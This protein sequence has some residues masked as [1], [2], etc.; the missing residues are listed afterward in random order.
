MKVLIISH[1]HPSSSR[2]GAEIV[3][4][5]LFKQFIE[6]NKIECHV[7]TVNP[8]Q[9]LPL[10]DP[11]TSSHVFNEHH[12]KSRSHPFSCTNTNPDTFSKKIEHL[13]RKIQP[14][15]IHLHHLLHLGIDSVD[16]IRHISPSAKVCL[17][18]HDYRSLCLNDGLMITS[19]QRLTCSTS[20]PDNCKR[21]FP[22]YQ[23]T[24]IQTR[25]DAYQEAV[26]NCDAII[27]PSQFL[28]NQLKNNGF[29]KQYIHLINNGTPYKPLQGNHPIKPNRFGFFG[30][31]CEAK[32][33]L[34][35]LIATLKL[36]KNTNK[37]FNISIFGGGLERQPAAFQHRVAH[38][39]KH[40]GSAIVKW[41]GPYNPND[42][43]ELMRTIDWVVVPSIWWENAP[44]V[45][46][47]AFALSIPV[48]GSNHGGIAEQIDGKGGLMVSANDSKHLAQ[49]MEEAIDNRSLHR[50]LQA[51]IQPPTSIKACA[52]QH[53]ILYKELL[54]TN[55]GK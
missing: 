42:L 36:K 29:C 45:I 39:R 32:G 46:Q 38:L 11:E 1:G 17:T 44:L 3:A 26:A 4:Y 8:F 23:K 18:L 47:E 34:N 25:H 22:I 49:R 33:L 16:I 14:D 6:H 48:I 13:L 10:S 12:I 55:A 7:V 21:C 15:I 28:I 24:A 53:L 9:D 20:S 27:S 2:G 40:L 5:N 35:L 19:K 54:D 31:T 50:Q 37:T 52:E 51:Q 30:T 41:H 43:P